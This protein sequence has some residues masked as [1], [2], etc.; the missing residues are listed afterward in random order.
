[1]ADRNDEDSG[2]DQTGDEAESVEDLTYGEALEELEGLLDELEHADVDVDIL[3]ERV[4]R[5]V[6]LVRYCRARLE[7]VTDD[8][9]GVVADLLSSDQD[10][11]PSTELEEE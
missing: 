10:P 5:G 11:E 1:M 6:A 2:Q 9:E 4:A 7:V 3:A 8:V